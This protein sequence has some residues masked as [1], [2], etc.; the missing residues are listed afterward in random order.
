M[1]VLTIMGS[2]RKGYGAIVM[3]QFEQEVKRI[4][5][6]DFEYLYLKDVHLERCRGCLNCF[7][8][9]E[10]MCPVKNDDR[11]EIFDKMD[12]AEGI[13]FMA[14]AYA[15]HVP[16]V[17]KNFFDRF[18]YLFHRPYFFGK[19]AI[20]ISNEGIYGAKKNTAY[21]EEVANVWGFNFVD[22]LE[23]RTIPSGGAEKKMLKKIKKT[24]KTF[25]KAL[26]GPRFQKPSLGAYL[27]FQVRKVLHGIA[28]DEQNA[29]YDYWLQQGWL[30]EDSKYFYDTKIGLGKRLITGLLCR[31]LKPKFKKMFAAGPKQIYDEYLKLNSLK[32]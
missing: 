16:A 8:R 1:K 6:V 3:E 7:F 11:D 13:I 21:F 25:A 2:P 10:D 18:S 4:Q 24:C 9:G 31:I 20:G 5:E 27:G 32:F 15:L 26:N 28:V 19:I 29:D 22:R 17:M 14:P 30:E 12:H 23:L